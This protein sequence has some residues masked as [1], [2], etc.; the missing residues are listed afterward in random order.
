VRKAGAEGKIDISQIEPTLSEC[1]PLTSVGKCDNVIS[2]CF[3]QVEK[4]LSSHSVEPLS[5]IR[6]Y[7][8]TCRS[9]GITG[10][11]FGLSYPLWISEIQ[12]G[13]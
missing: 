9:V 10:L 2:G 3:F 4:D 8:S 7:D 6:Y 5:L 11:G 13:A 12:E 1:E